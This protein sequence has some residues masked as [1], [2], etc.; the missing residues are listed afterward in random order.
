MTKASAA[1]A[2]KKAK[3]ASS[4]AAQLFSVGKVEGNAAAPNAPAPTSSVIS[5]LLQ[6]TSEARNG[7]PAGTPTIAAV[8]TI[9]DPAAHL[10]LGLAHLRKTS[11]SLG[12]LIDKHDFTHFLNL[13]LPTPTSPSPAM[14]DPFRYLARGIVAQQVSVS[15]ARSILSRF[16]SL[17]HPSSSS[18]EEIALTLS[19]P[20]SF[21]PSPAQVIETPVATL[22][23][24]GLSGQKAA[25]M[26]SLASHLLDDPVLASH[27][28]L[29]ELGDMEIV[30]R[31]TKVH[32][33]GVWSAE[34]F[35]IFGLGRW[36]V[37]STGDL[38]V[39]RGMAVWDG[40]DVGRLKAAGRK[41]AG[42][43]GKVKGGVKWK[44]M[45][46]GDMRGLSEGFAPWRTLFCLLMWKAS[47]VSVE[48]AVG[49]G[50]EMR[51]VKQVKEEEEEEEEEEVVVAP[52]VKRTR[53]NV[54]AKKEDVKTEA[55]T[56]ELAVVAPKA[57]RTRKKVVTKDEDVIAEVE[58]LEP[59][60][61]PPKAKRTR[62]K[63]VA[64]EEEGV[65]AEAEESEPALKVKRTRKGTT[66]AA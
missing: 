6:V 45:S 58:E 12:P 57:K 61:V 3:P 55:E 21:F 17:F 37:F 24:V 20:T 2:A 25:Y 53:K 23:T 16:V 30:E 59:A 32:G 39:Q 11:P 65:I 26:H 42:V 50:K 52:R 7:A 14:D 66:K 40:R 27:A 4:A 62:R 51:K 36:D 19:D 15:A 38:G 18:A 33:L 34:M 49:K 56:S 10:A 48:K 46:E 29:R 1:A 5:S 43:G 64:K 8:P 31:L 22:R 44:Y 35:L 60:A 63:A 9:A 47:E 54:V 28:A 41:E 13:H